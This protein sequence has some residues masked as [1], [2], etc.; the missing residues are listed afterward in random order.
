[1][2]DNEDKSHVQVLPQVICLI[3]PTPSREPEQEA[4]KARQQRSRIAQGLDVRDDVRLAASLAAALLDGFFEQPG[5]L[6]G[7]T[8]ENFSV[9]LRMYA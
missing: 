8:L 2:W 1:M 3:P 7:A 9:M 6:R 5:N 4:E